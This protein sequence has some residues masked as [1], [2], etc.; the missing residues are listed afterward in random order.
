MSSQPTSALT[1]SDL[2]LETAIK[3][4]VAYYGADGTEVAQIPT[5]AYDLAECKR[6]ANNA[7]RMF[8]GDAPKTGWRWSRPVKSFTLWPSVAVDASRTASAGAYDSTNGQTLITLTGGVFYETMEDKDIVFT[9]TGTFR[10][11]QYVTSTTAY[12]AGDASAVSAETYSITAD[13]DYTLPR[14]FGGDHGGPVT[15][16]ADTNQTTVIQWVDE[17]EIRNMRTITADT[18]GFPTLLAVKLA[19]TIY[20]GERRR[21]VLATYPIPYSVF[22]VEFKYNVYFDKLTSLTEYAPS[23]IVHDETLRAACRAVVERDV[24]RITNGPDWQY[25]RSNRLPPSHDADARS[26]PRRLGYFGN[27]SGVHPNQGRYPPRRPNVTY[28]TP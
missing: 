16:G 14:D 12:V 1:F 27:P 26:G 10:I 20:S 17:S 15:F 2:I 5:D 3:M 6:H 22:T 25:Y 18:T 23:P 8:I 11:K 19:D 28:D 24:D 4:G 9:T 7:I 13:G 21:Y